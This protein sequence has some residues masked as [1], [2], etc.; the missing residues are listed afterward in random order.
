MA[1]PLFGTRGLKPFFQRCFNGKRFRSYGFDG[2]HSPSLPFPVINE[3][4][5]VLL[6]IYAGDCDSR[7]FEVFWYAAGGGVA[8]FY[9]SADV[10]SRLA[11]RLIFWGTISDPFCDLCFVCRRHSSKVNCRLLRAIGAFRL[12]QASNELFL[13]PPFRA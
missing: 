3:F 7:I 6:P 11:V 2:V 13:R 5:I 1:T 9:D 10:K 12:K 4:D 8:Q